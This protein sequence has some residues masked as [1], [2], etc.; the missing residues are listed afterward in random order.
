MSRTVNQQITPNFRSLNVAKSKLA[1]KILRNFPLEKWNQHPIII[2]V[3][4][5]PDSVALLRIADELSKNSSNTQLIVAHANHKQRGKESENDQKFVEAL[6]GQLNIACNCQPLPVESDEATEGLESALRDLR[7]EWFGQLANQTGARY[8]M[9]AHNQNDQT[10]T[11]LFRLMRGTGI[12]GLAGIP[13]QR[14]L[15]EGVTLLR[16]M[17]NISRDEIV[18]YLNVI[19]QPVRM[20]ASNASSIFTRNRIRNELIPK[21]KSDFSPQLDQRI[22]SLSAQ[23]AECQ[24]YLD[25]IAMALLE[26][27]IHFQ[28]EAFSVDCAQLSNQPAILVRHTLVL[29]WKRMGW[30]LRDMTY[31]KWQ[32]AASVI[33]TDT[34]PE[35]K[36]PG[37]IKMT[38][39][40]SSILFQREG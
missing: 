40:D 15:V 21:I 39:Q 25:S 7:Y 34:H 9:T 32:T 6:A 12:L 37:N 29:A 38:R 8:V 27:A 13:K 19:Q 5:G 11:V 17:L 20:D 3:S 18:E 28:S 16:P 10:E 22:Q 35:S 31:A 36:L 2:G 24:K 14:R 26:N 4:G 33:T 23:A 30:S 1:H